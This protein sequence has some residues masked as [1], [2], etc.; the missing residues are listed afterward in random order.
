MGGAVQVQDPRSRSI[1]VQP[2]A[3]PAFPLSDRL[4][5]AHRSVWDDM[6]ALLLAASVILVFLNFQDYGL[7]HDEE[8][9]AIY[10]EKLLSWYS[11]LFQDNSAFEY[12]DLFWY[13]GLFDLVAALLNKVSPFGYYETRHL[14]GGLAGTAGLAGAWCAGRMAAGPRAGFLAMAFL[15]FT[16]AYVGH[17]FNN[18]K[19]A[20]FAAAMLWSCFAIAC[21][22]RQLP[23]PSWRSVIGLGIALGV[24]FGIRVG[25]LLLIGY[26]GLAI[27]VWLGLSARRDGLARAGRDLV[28]PILGRALV[29][30]VV[31][32]ALIAVFWPYGV[33]NPANP[34][35]ALSHFSR[36]DIDIVS[37][38]NGRKVEATDLPVTYLPGYLAVTLPELVLAGLA[39]LAAAL[40]VRPLRAQRQDAAMTGM[41]VL[42][43][44]FPIGFFIA[45]RPTA[46]DGIRHFLFVV[47]PLVVL[48]ALGVDRL[49]RWTEQRFPAAGRALVAA[50]LVAGVIQG[51]IMGRLHPNEYIYYNALVG[52]VRGAQN[53]WEMDY[54]SNS[55]HEAVDRLAD[56]VRLENGGTAPVEPVKVNICGND[57]SATY[58]FPPY[59]EQVR[60]LGEA[61]YV[62]AFTQA[63]CWKTWRGRPIIEVERFGAVL[64][65]VKDRRGLPNPDEE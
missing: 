9:Q 34:L 63:D 60:T 23:R 36:Y 40:V 19:D 51:W 62:I 57:L 30:L 64:S 38:F 25:A 24:A 18:P 61:D 47:P 55:M 48:S 54:W 37:M 17:S 31:A 8:V 10:G 11:S 52:G 12:L 46:Y 53:N 35:K 14:L 6:A 59:L 13:G 41:L 56:L 20:P 42:A 49:W 1:A 16:P 32:Y 58:F 45:F 29:A 3:A 22:V 5:R 44:L 39:L 21:V 7:T 26:A 27:L 15:A 50:L 4:A 28:G 33:M 65:V 43:A 2:V